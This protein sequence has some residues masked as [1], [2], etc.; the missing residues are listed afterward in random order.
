MRGCFPL[1]KG[2]AVEPASVHGPRW[3]TEAKQSI[4]ADNPDGLVSLMQQ[5]DRATE[6]QIFCIAG[7]LEISQHSPDVLEEV[8][9]AGATQEILHAMRNSHGDAAVQG[10]GARALAALTVPER[11]R[12]IAAENG[13]VAVIVAAAQTF[14]T[15]K[16]VA[17]NAVEVLCH[18]G[19]NETCQGQMMARAIPPTLVVRGHAL[20][21]FEPL[22]ATRPLLAGRS[23]H[24]HRSVP[25]P[26]AGAALRARHWGSG[27]S[28]RTGAQAF[29]AKETWPIRDCSRGE[30]AQ[31]K[32][33]HGT[34]CTQDSPRR[35]P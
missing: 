24:I 16:V 13:A 19:A 34:I 5:Y 23:R 8:L 31:A 14:R 9:S 22:V 17:A 26:A 28:C 20:P 21:G 30:P 7:L 11:G 32:A 27:L 10:Q 15:D 4:A 33:Q 3:L 25:A 6:V 29:R 12:Q 18:L 2:T 35:F 1:C